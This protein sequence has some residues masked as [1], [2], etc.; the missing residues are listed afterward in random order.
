ME[1]KNLTLQST[2]HNFPFRL[3]LINTIFPLQIIPIFLVITTLF[4]FNP[5]SRSSP[6]LSVLLR[7]SVSPLSHALSHQHFHA[8]SSQICHTSPIIGILLRCSIPPSTPLSHQHFHALS[9]QI[10]HSSPFLGVLLRCSVPPSTPTFQRYS[11]L[12]YNRLSIVA[13]PLRSFPV[14][15]AAISWQH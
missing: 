12:L 4:S 14:E 11:P 13:S 6:F 9:S 10:C 1:I 15:A 5:S 2:P 8:L 7:C 3:Y